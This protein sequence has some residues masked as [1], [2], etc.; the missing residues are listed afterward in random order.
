MICSYIHT[1]EGL[2]SMLSPQFYQNLPQMR[3]EFTNLQL[4]NLSYKLIV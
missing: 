2:P 4:E 3:T 1:P